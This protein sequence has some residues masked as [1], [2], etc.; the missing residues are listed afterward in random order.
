VADKL[1]QLVVIHAEFVALHPFLDGNGR[2][3]RMLVPLFL[4][5]SGLISQPMFYISE[6]FEANRDEYYDKL[7]DVSV[8][9]SWSQWYE[10]FLNAVI[11]QAKMNTK[12]H[13]KY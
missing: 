1:I 6:Y 4:W 5:Q 11:N 10:F 8:N 2:L 3:G 9:D 13:L 12:K 7:L